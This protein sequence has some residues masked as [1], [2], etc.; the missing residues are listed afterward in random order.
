MFL[1]CFGK[2][3]ATINCYESLSRRLEDVASEGNKNVSY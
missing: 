3:W 1:T 2:C